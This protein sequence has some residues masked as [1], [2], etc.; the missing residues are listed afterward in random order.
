MYSLTVVV[1]P[2]LGVLIHPLRSVNRTNAWNRLRFLLDSS[3]IGA[4]VLVLI[5]SRSLVG[6]AV[7]QVAWLVA[8][9][10]LAAVQWTGRSEGGSVERISSRS[11]VGFGAPTMLATLP[12]F[13]NFRVDQLIIQAVAGS[14][15]LGLYATAVTWCAASLPVINTISILALPRL[16]GRTVGRDASAARFIRSS[17]GLAVVTAA[18]LSVTAPVAILMLFGQAFSKSILLAVPLCFVT[19]LLGVTTTTEEVLRAYGDVRYPARAQLSG[20]ALN[21]VLLAALI[22][23]LGSWG[24]VIASGVAYLWVCIKVLERVR[25]RAELDHRSMIPTVHDIRALWS[26]RLSVPPR[27]SAGAPTVPSVG[28]NDDVIDPR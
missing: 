8:L 1:L 17:L 23:L 28:S 18:A 7:V 24:A 5:H 16:A 20:L 4:A 9:L 27:G 14:K 3:M 22:P 19:A 10:I 25:V 11:I 6:I 13:L 26:L 12:F 15:E 2:T 21:I